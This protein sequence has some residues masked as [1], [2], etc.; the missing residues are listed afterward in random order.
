MRIKSK[1][2]TGKK[3]KQRTIRYSH[4]SFGQTIELAIGNISFSTQNRLESSP[5]ICGLE[6]K[7]DS[8]IACPQ[9]LKSRFG[10]AIITVKK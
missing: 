2:K 1:R 3:S 4:G 5:Q 10:Q 6:R 7:M 8:K 9:P